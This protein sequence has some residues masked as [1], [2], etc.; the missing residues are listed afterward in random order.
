LG[1]VVA[2]FALAI[3]I[4]PLYERN[5]LFFSEM[6]RKSESCVKNK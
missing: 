3:N 5:S 6:K 4:L 2:L 1:G